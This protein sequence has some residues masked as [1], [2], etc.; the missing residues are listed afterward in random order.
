MFRARR[1]LRATPEIAVA[2][3][4]MAGKVAIRVGVPRR[5]SFGLAEPGQ[6]ALTIDGQAHG[7]GTLRWTPMGGE[8]HSVD[9]GGL[10]WWTY[11]FPVELAEQAHAALFGSALRPPRLMTRIEPIEA[12]RS[13][14]LIRLLS[15]ILSFE[16]AVPAA[17]TG[18]LLRLTLEPFAALP[19][20]E[21]P[22]GTRRRRSVV[23][24][25]VGIADAAAGE[26]VPL[27]EVCRLLETPMRS[28]NAAANAVLGLSAAAYLR[29]RRLHAA[30]TTLSSGMADSVTEAATLHGFYELSRF[31]GQYRA[32]FG[33]RPSETLRQAQRMLR[34]PP[35][36]G[37]ARPAQFVSR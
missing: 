34:P 33:E 13:T 9:E 7:F 24:G 35:R 19:A 2:R 23:D 1:W 31:A 4:Q 3:G 36:F 26:P 17:L 20:W 28:L 14:T 10:T 18:E 22:L 12:D 21:P 32:L 29:L 25:L 27:T 6:A 8:V 16:G 37:G 15:C 5:A 30:R 11:S